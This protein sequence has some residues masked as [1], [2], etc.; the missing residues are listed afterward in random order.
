MKSQR[1]AERLTFNSIMDQA[2]LERRLKHTKS[3]VTPTPTR[4]RL[5]PSGGMDTKEKRKLLSM[6]F[7]DKLVLAS[8]SDGLTRL[9]TRYPLKPKDRPYLHVS[10]T[11]FSPLTNT[12]TIGTQTS[13]YPP[14]K[15]CYDGSE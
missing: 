13:T 11:S 1:R 2:E 6:N 14:V 3:S 15:L 12:R 5:L 4:R 7:G 9:D 8:Y 10:P